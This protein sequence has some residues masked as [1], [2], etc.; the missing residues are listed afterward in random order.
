MDQDEIEAIIIAAIARLYEEE[1][2]AIQYDVAERM[3]SARLAALLAPSFS[4]HRVHAEYNRHGIDPKGIEMPDADGNPS[5]KLVY[6][7]IIVHRPGTDDENLLVIEMKK[8]TN[9]MENQQ[10]L[11][12]LDRIKYQ[13]GYAHA[14]FIRLPAGNGAAA[15]NADYIW[16]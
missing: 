9:K 11:E 3:L 4:S 16:R 7:D 2:Q 5:F 8:S 15:E 10:D 1:A 14:L 13:L 12:K 6:P